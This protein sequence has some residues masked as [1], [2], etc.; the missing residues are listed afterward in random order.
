MS[1]ESKVCKKCGSVIPDKRYKSCPKCSID[2]IWKTEEWRKVSD[3]FKKIP[4]KPITNPLSTIKDPPYLMTG[5]VLDELFGGGIR[6]GQLIE[7]YGPWG[8]GKSQFCFTAVVE[9]KKKVIFIDSEETFSVK[10]IKE[11]AKA[12]GKSDE[13]IADLD[14]RILLYQPKDWREQ[15]AILHQLPKADD[16]D[17]IIID[18]LMAFFREEEDFVGRQTLPL[19]QSLARIHLSKLKRDI[20]KRYNAVVVIT[21]QVSAQP[22]SNPYTPRYEKEQGV[23][24]HS[25]HHIPQVILYFRK[26]KDP[27][28]IARVMKSNEQANEERVFK[29]GVAG[30]EDTTKTKEDELEEPTE[31]VEQAEETN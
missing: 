24:G 2:E 20:S 1:N 18:S 19:R 17:L 12:R 9:S 21:N 30:I 7:I 31:H 14:K 4:I 16:V 10:R 11:I 5:T 6:R 8:S 26:A 15:L 28:R 13:E 25:V 22:D 3:V 29:L 27:K 23:G